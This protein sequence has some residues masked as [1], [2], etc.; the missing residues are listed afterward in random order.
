MVCLEKS[1]LPPDLQMFKPSL[2]GW[3]PCHKLTDMSLAYF[4]TISSDQTDFDTFVN[5]KAVAKQAE[6]LNDLAKQLGVT[7][8]DDFLGMSEDVA[9][10]FDIKADVDL[11]F[12]PEAGLQTVEALI[13]HLEQTPN[14]VKNSKGVLEDLREYQEVLSQIKAKGLEWRFEMDF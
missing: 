7:P 9:E 13:K 11:W 10:E 4:V 3:L 12:K 2:T 8:L 14:A 1:R 5:G 6:V